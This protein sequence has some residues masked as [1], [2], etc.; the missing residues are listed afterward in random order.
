MEPQGGSMPAR[1]T[2]YQMPSPIKVML[3]A[4]QPKS[5]TAM[6]VSRLVVESFCL[7][8]EC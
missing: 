4:S 5:P 6:M 3:S 1:K 7:S 8:G 2:D